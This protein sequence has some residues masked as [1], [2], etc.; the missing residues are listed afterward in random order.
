[1]PRD[2][3][4]RGAQ[5]QQQAVRGQLRTDRSV[6]Q[7]MAHHLAPL[8]MLA[9]S[10]FWLT[11]CA[12]P[13][14]LVFGYMFTRVLCRQQAYADLVPCAPFGCTRIL[15]GSGFW[16]HYF[17]QLFLRHYTITQ[18]MSIRQVLDLPLPSNP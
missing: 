12:N 13:P 5:G 18:E 3:K 4:I 16:E 6:L 2:I 9:R 15:P 17:S 8:M 10:L 14:V 11:A 7:A 1:M